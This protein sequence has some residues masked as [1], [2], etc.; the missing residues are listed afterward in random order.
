MSNLT[1]AKTIPP[2]PPP[3]RVRIE[4]GAA[5]KSDYTFTKPFRCGRDKSCEVRLV[6]TAVSRFHAEIW[7]SDGEWRILDQQSANGTYVDRKRVERAPIS[8]QAK[9]ELGEDVRVPEEN[10]IGVE[11]KGFYYIM[12]S[13]QLE[14]L[15]TALRSRRI[16]RWAGDPTASSRKLKRRAR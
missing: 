15:A 7:F 3:I 12:E 9:V 6:D 8:A 1:D 4:R 2:S 11:N 14:R 13:F 10:R 5:E 16:P